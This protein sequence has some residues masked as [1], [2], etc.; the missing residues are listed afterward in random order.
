MFEVVAIES[1]K[2]ILESNYK[3]KKTHSLKTI[4]GTKP[5]IFVWLFMYAVYCGRKSIGLRYLC[6]NILFFTFTDEKSSKNADQSKRNAFHNC[7]V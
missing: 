7:V 2:T 3:P 4:C 5:D 1:V 6:V